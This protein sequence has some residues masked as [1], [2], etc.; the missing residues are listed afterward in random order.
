MNPNKLMI[1]GG[2]NSQNGEH[3]RQI[4]TWEGS[5]I[6]KTGELVSSDEFY[7][8]NSYENNDHI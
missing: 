6:K 8:N 3:T 5:E 1:V 2:S 4:Y 7:Y